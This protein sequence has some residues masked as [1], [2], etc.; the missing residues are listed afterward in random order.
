M[1]VLQVDSRGQ[2]FLHLAVS[3][4]DVEGVIFL[5]SV[6]VDVNSKAQNPTLATPLH[7]AVKKG[8]E[9]LVRHLVSLVMTSSAK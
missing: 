2:N 8:S 4:E 9:L 7:Y 6:R 5:L 3:K 1:A